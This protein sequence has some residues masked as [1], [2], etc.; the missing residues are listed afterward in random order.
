VRL[1]PAPGRYAVYDIPDPHALPSLSETDEGRVLLL[2]D[3]ADPVAPRTY[4]LPPAFTLDGAGRAATEG[5]WWIEPGTAY[6]APHIFYYEYATHSVTTL[7][8]RAGWTVA[9]PDAPR[10]RL[11]FAETTQAP[12]GSAQ[13]MLYL[14]DARG[15]V[16]EPVAVADG[17]VQGAQISPDGRYLIFTAVQRQATQIQ[18]RLILV[19]LAVPP[20]PT[21]PRVQ[22]RQ[23]VLDTLTLPLDNALSAGRLDTRF[24]PSAP[25]RVLSDLTDS[26]GRRQTI[27][28]LDSGIR[29]T[30]WI[31]LPAPCLRETFA[32]SPSGGFVITQHLDPTGF[33]MVIQ[34][35][36]RL[37]EQHAW[38][39]PN[40][41]D[42][43]AVTAFSRDEDYL[44]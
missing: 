19:R 25:T 11:L 44:L 20:D 9:A 6:P 23:S 32:V 1:F 42:G 41:P 38:Q 39:V 22:P 4:A 37:I 21:A 2:A 10:T 17:T 36:D 31:G 16:P 33:R 8:A 7:P 43:W 15:A 12:A 18:Q 13:T 24:L 40:P 30:F 14:S 27:F 35:A 28:D 5:F 34:P 29:T 3:L 26:R